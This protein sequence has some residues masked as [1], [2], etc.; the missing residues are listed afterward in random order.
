MSWRL[1]SLLSYIKANNSNPT[2]FER[3][4]HVLYDY[5]SCAV[6]SQRVFASQ[7]FSPESII[8]DQVQNH[9]LKWNITI[10]VGP[11]RAIKYLTRSEVP[12]SDK[13]ASLLQFK[14]IYSCRKFYSADF[15]VDAATA[16]PLKTKN[17]K[18]IVNMDRIYPLKA[19]CQ[20]NK[21][22]REC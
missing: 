5:L 14:I 2:Q 16:S 9:R 21:I 20:G 15:F 1:S 17:D 11:S 13:H 10:R 18:L 8:F 7:T 3:L 19:A 4:G 12:G 6:V 22:S